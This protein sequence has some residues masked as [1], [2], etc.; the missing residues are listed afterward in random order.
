MH[1]VSAWFDPA[2]L[3]A[4]SQAVPSNQEP[5]PNWPAGITLMVS[6]LAL[7]R[8][9]LDMVGDREPLLFCLPA[10]ILAT[11]AAA[12]FHAHRHRLGDRGR[13]VIG[14]V[15]GFSALLWLQLSFL[16]FHSPIHIS[17]AVKE[18]WPRL[19]LGMAFEVVVRTL[20]RLAVV[21][22]GLFVLAVLCLGLINRNRAAACHHD[23][24]DE[25]AG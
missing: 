23:G 22:M 3:D 12:A 24:R 13:W 15:A 11:S 5:V 19:H 1:N 14:S 21:G 10:S 18:A 17:S 7:T 25:H 9:M 4:G 2:G 6:V 20:G 8:L 16:M